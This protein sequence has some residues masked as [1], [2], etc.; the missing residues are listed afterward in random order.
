MSTKVLVPFEGLM[1]AVEIY[2]EDNG[3]IKEDEFLVFADLGLEVD[4][5]GFVE[6]EV[7]LK[8]E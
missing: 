4:A 5:N 6:I 7:E 2:L 8:T 1:E 3:Y